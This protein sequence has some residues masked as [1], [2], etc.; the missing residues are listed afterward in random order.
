MKRGG[1]SNDPEQLHFGTLQMARERLTVLGVEIW[2]MARPQRFFYLKLRVFLF[3]RR[4]EGVQ[5]GPVG[6]QPITSG[7]QGI[8]C[9]DAAQCIWRYNAS[10]DAHLAPRELPENSQ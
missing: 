9:S 8:S 5:E 1:V 3:E 4:Q 7:E 2:V 6:T 10:I